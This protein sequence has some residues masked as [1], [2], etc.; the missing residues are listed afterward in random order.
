FMT[1]PS[2]AKLS[3]RTFAGLAAATS[4]C[5]PFARSAA[6]QDAVKIGAIFPLTGANSVF[7]NQNYQGVDIAVDLI[8]EA[9]GI[10]GRKISLF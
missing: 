7:G 10:N 4:I 6:A 2:H 9:G 8:N 1:V 5:G 3:R